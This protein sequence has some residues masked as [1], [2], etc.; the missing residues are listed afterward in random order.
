MPEWVTSTFR[1]ASLLWWLPLALLPLVIHL[2]NRLRRKNIDWGAIQ[3][4]LASHVA[5][6]RRVLLEEAALLSIRVLALAALV[7]AACRPFV[8]NPYFGG[9][10]GSRQDV[11]I[12]L[13]GSGSMALRQGTM[14]QFDRAVGAAGEVIDTLGDGDTVSVIVAGP[15][16][17]SLS[18]R[19]EFLSRSLRGGLKRRLAA[20]SPSSGGLDMIHAV[21]AAQGMLS[22]GRHA[23]KQMIIIT[24]GQA[25]GWGGDQVRRWEFLHEA[26]AQSGAQPKV[27]VLVVG[28]A[29]GRVVNA[30]VADIRPGRRV[31]GIDRSVALHVTVTNTGSE[32]MPDRS[33]ELYVDDRKRAEQE[34]GLLHAGASNTLEFQHQFSRPGS[35]LIRAKLTGEDRIALDDA[36]YLA[37]EVYD[38]LGVL[39]VDGAPSAQPLRSETSYLASAL[40][41]T[42]VE[43][44][45][46]IDYLA[47]AKRIELDQTDSV[48]PSEH[49]V[50]V[51]ANV[52][53]LTRRF[54]D[55][56]ER[57]V[58]DGG[59]LLIAPGDQVD[60]EWYNAEMY[61]AG[62][63]LGPCQLGQA[64][65][66]AVKRE[67]SQSIAA[68][69]VEHPAVR[70]SADREKTDIGKVQAF[71]WYKLNVSE[72][73]AGRAILRLENGDPLLVEKRFGRGNVLMT[74]SPLDIDWSNLPATRCYVVLVHEMVYWLSQP[75]LSAWNVDPAEVV[76]ARF[77]TASVAPEGKVIDPSGKMS[78]VAGEADGASLVFRYAQTDLP[79]VYRL[80][81]TADGKERSFYFTSRPAAKESSLE[82]LSDDVRSELSDRLGA[83]FVTDVDTIRQQ[84]EID[85]VGTEIWQVLVAVVVLLLLAEVLLTRRIAA[86][87]HGVHE[88]EL[89]F[90]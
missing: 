20:L 58:R 45:P 50:V 22:A 8:R 64:D 83:Q 37:V 2:L 82:P 62:K 87:R 81:V 69:T 24:D 79:G 1:N 76:E 74:A 31:I 3:F 13:D 52:P 53:R 88:E 66:D 86:A 38:R 54:L 46:R 7:A 9:A 11:A 71:R 80:A 40:D 18:D 70:L 85:V 17:K 25:E 30:A 42:E 23:H 57:F 21:D 51:L 29:P 36:T 34:V 60:A 61:A 73:G 43:G 39:L 16:A 10:G 28:G 77:A 49:R 5:R 27:H 14:T 59:G 67:V 4:L 56:L 84:L 78:E 41:P 68:A 65:G 48:D 6:Q 26:M 12:V 19:P 44:E 90:G 75:T 55:R 89:A 72:E 35:H 15:V 63:G 33:V 47:D 32:S